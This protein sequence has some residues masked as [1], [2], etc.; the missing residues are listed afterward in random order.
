MV[1]AGRKGDHT[2]NFNCGRMEISMNKPGKPIPTSQ[3]LRI[4]ISI[5]LCLLLC[6]LIPAVQTLA[7]C[8][9][10]IMCSQSGGSESCKSGLTRLLGVVCGGVMGVI[11]ALLHSLIPSGVVFALMAGLGVVGNLLLCKVVKMPY[12]TARVSAMSFVLVILLGGATYAINRF[13]GTL[14]GGLVAVAVAT[15]WEQLAKLRSKAA[16]K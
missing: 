3:D 7:A 13:I 5:A 16:A 9:S 15:V 2:V 14:C 11:V 12:I 1:S 6:Q 8:T 10:A 4:G